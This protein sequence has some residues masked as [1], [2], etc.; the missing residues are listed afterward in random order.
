MS[1]KEKI[2]ILIVF[3][4]AAV[5]IVINEINIRPKLN[6]I[7]DVKKIL[8]N[9]D[10]YELTDDGIAE[11]FI[12]YDGYTIHG[13]HYDVKGTG[14]IFIDKSNSVFLNFSALLQ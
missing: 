2:L 8:K 5:P 3:V 14:V 12:V 9:I 1:K 13:D 4:A 10:S 7:N 11:E 6:L